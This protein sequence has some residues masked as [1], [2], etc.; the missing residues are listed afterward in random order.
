MPAF[1][2]CLAWDDLRRDG[3]VA[4]PDI[5]LASHETARSRFLHLDH[6]ESLALVINVIVFHRGCRREQVDCLT[7]DLH[8]AEFIARGR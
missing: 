7:G 2:D 5:A 8:R 3:P 1:G 6:E 4:G